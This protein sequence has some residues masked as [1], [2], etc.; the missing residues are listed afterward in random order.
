MMSN[1]LTSQSSS[2]QKLVML[3]IAILLVACLPSSI[4][5]A[6]AEMVL[7]QIHVVSRQG[8]VATIPSGDENP[9]T[10]VLSP[11]GESQMFQ[12]GAW[13]RTQ[14]QESSTTE[15]I[16]PNTQQDILPDEYLPNRVR[17]ESSAEEATMVSAQAMAR[18]LFPTNNI[19]LPIF[20]QAARNDIA[21]AAGDQ[22][23]AFQNDLEELT[24]ASDY[25]SDWNQMESAYMLLLQQLAKMDLLASYVTGVGEK[26]YVPLTQV[27][28]VYDLIREVKLTCNEGFDSTNIDNCNQL[29]VSPNAAALLSDT[30]WDDLKTLAQFAE[31]TKYGT[32]RSGQLL[33][34]NLLREIVD[35]M[36]D[37]EMSQPQEAGSKRVFVMSADY[38]TLI[39]LMTALQVVSEEEQLDEAFPGYGS[40]IVFEL[41]QSDV[42]PFDHAVRVLYKK[43]GNAKA[44]VLRL[45]EFCF[46]KDLCQMAHFTNLLNSAIL[47]T[48]DW[49]QECGNDTSDV[50]LFYSRLGYQNA[51][52]EQQQGQSTTTSQSEENYIDCTDKKSTRVEF[53][54]IFFGGIALGVILTGLSILLFRCLQSLCKKK[55]K[56]R[57]KRRSSL[58]ALN[59]KLNFD[60]D[61]KSSTDTP[62]TVMSTTPMSF[63]PSYWTNS[64]VVVKSSGSIDGQ[65]EDSDDE[66]IGDVSLMSQDDDE[67]SPLDDAAKSPMRRPARKGMHKRNL[68]V[69]TPTK[70]PSKVFSPEIV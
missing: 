28:K 59:T 64:P 25:S 56:G 17:L 53:A 18:G 5:V 13:I 45:G 67:C 35:R 2:S 63:F 27:G 24:K 38:P 39:A 8:S 10:D 33:G 29:S 68:S 7:R 11:V 49:C 55:Q 43:A 44:S 58:V 54:A 4:P 37:D 12:L 57:V 20:T 9:P 60:N 66:A 61:K 34:G 42:S 70:L 3:S 21:I 48:S 36:L 40:A 62:A 30:E 65:G 14:F 41:Y 32:E 52:K 1:S 16:A 6:S 22:C 47:G 69:P 19:G 31:N 26:A 51:L 15:V 46:E 50:C 23:P